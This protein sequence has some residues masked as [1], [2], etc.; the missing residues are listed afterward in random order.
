MAPSYPCS[1][2]SQPVS[3]SPLTSLGSIQQ[4]KAIVIITQDFDFYLT[5]RLL[6]S[7]MHASMKHPTLLERPTRQ[8][9]K[10]SLWLTASWAPRPLAPQPTGNWLLTA[11]VN[12]GENPS[13]VR[14]QMRPQPQPT[15]SLQPVI[16]WSSH[17]LLYG[18]FNAI[19][20]CE[21]EVFWE[22]LEK[23]FLIERHLR[24]KERSLFSAPPI[25]VWES[26]ARTDAALCDRQ[27]LHPRGRVNR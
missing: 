25:S 15:P 17:Q 23:V 4:N 19:L 12:L 16:P 3:S 1:W 6:S 18:P 22:A 7:Q 27:E 21:T 24:R 14:S 2:C 10:C 20:V 13:P 11:H 9:T 26:I 5:S 8:G